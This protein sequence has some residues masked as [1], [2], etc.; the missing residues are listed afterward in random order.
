[1]EMTNLRT[2]AQQMLEA[3]EQSRVFVTTREKIKHPEGTEWY[4]GCITDL[5]AALAEPVEEQDIEDAI[6]AAYWNF[7]ARKQGLNEWAKAPQ[8]ERD[9]FKAEARKLIVGAVAKECEQC[10]QF[11]ESEY[12]HDFKKTWREGLAQAIRLR[13]EQ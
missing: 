9:A 8:S 6:E 10:A 1:M 4:D 11:V 5:R 3:L 12:V 7:D 2:V 13:G